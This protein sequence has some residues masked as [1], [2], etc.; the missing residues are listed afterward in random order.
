MIM[1]TMMTIMPGDMSTMRRRAGGSFLQTRHHYRDKG[2]CLSR[3]CDPNQPS[4]SPMQK[5]ILHYLLLPG[6]PRG[7]PLPTALWA[8]PSCG[9]P[10]ACTAPPC[11]SDTQPLGG[12]VEEGESHAG[13]VSWLLRDP[14]LI[15][16]LMCV[17]VTHVCMGM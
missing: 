11:C 10:C 3:S 6:C 4:P 1:M 16:W 8:C 5:P 12:G 9:P 17:F 14:C 13:G 15:S 7:H 2:H